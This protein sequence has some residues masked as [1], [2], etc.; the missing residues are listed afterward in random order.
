MSLTSG[1]WALLRHSA[2]RRLWIGQAISEIG[3]GLTGLA[4][5]IVVFRLTGSAAALGAL[6]VL[7][8]IPQLALGLHAGVLVDRWERRRVMVATDLIRAA[9]VAGLMVVQGPGDIWLLY[10]LATL[11]AAASVFFEPARAAILPHL[12]TRET[13]LGA[14]GVL[15]STR[16]VAGVM[17]TALAG[18]LLALP[19]GARVAFGVDAISF[20]VSAIAIASLR[21][22]LR[23]GAPESVHVALVRGLRFLFASR[24]LVG[25]LLTFA[26]TVLGV[27]AVNVVF[28]P[29]VIG[30]LHG[31]S[32]LI[33]FMRAAQ[34]VGMV[35]A[36]TA[37]A[38]ISARVAP[39]QLMA[40]AILGLALAL[41]G[42]ALVHH[43]AAFVPLLL[44]AGVC[45]T[46]I[47]SSSATLLQQHVPDALR[48]R[49]ES[50]LDTLLM[51][52]VMAAAAGAG[53]LA[54]RA[55][56]RPVFLGAGIV[57]LL[58]GVLAHIAL[59]EPEPA[60]ER[61]AIGS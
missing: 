48:G 37:I 44:A 57:T 30:E 18:V 46:L 40:P 47:Q 11:H 45:S 34:T 31:S 16:V 29:F 53:A 35:A 3:D 61:S 22:P 2:F 12:V 42:L 50:A 14:N 41:C 32:A 59:R 5:A 52:V 56:S 28:V 7:T 21:V 60:R 39:A 15:Q 51:V 24:M 49:I 8:S 38:A 4:L 17:G 58:G 54:D 25:L 1:H 36:G 10:A 33:G 19:Q 9:L 43:W 27:S 20:I 23:T 6:T 26:V 55:G 13:L